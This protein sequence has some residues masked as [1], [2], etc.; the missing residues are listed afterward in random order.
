VPGSTNRS[1][2]IHVTQKRKP[3]RRGGGAFRRRISRKRHG[4]YHSQQH[5]DNNGADLRARRTSDAH[6]RGGGDRWCSALGITATSNAPVL[7]LC[8]RLIEAGHDPSARLEAYRGTTLSLR[9]RSIGE[10]AKLTVHEATRGR[11]RFTL[12]DDL[13][14]LDAHEKRGV[15]PPVAQKPSGVVR[16]GDKSRPRPA[17][18][19]PVAPNDLAAV[20]L[21]GPLQKHPARERDAPAEASE[22]A[23]G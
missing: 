4:I 20:S 5:R 17:L 11:P 2:S 16:P 1:T 23:H 15:G 7:A 22:A 6:P 8:R 3:P 21:A 13:A 10:G 9:V 19:T 12:T 18:A 14:R